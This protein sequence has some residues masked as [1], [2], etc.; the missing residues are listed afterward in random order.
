MCKIALGGAIAER[1]R[2]GRGVRHCKLVKCQHS[3]RPRLDGSHSKL[4]GL[5]FVSSCVHEQPR[6][7]WYA[8]QA[9][10][11]QSNDIP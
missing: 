6:T 11:R 3:H 4:K 2:E 7:L 9:G 8:C 10:S 1:Q 5:S